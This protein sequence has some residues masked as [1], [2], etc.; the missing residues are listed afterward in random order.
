MRRLFLNG[1]TVTAQ[2][3]S[4]A[5]PPIGNSPTLCAGVTLPRR[6][7]FSCKNYTTCKLL[8]L[9]DA[10]DRADGNAL[11][12]VMVADAFNAGG[13]IDYIEGA[14]AFGDG[15]SGAIGHARAAGNTIVLNFHGHGLGF[16]FYFDFFAS[17]R[18]TPCFSVSIDYRLMFAGFCN[19]R[20]MIFDLATKKPCKSMH[21]FRFTKN[22]KGKHQLL[23]RKKFKAA[24]PP[25][26]QKEITKL[27]RK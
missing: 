14:I 3:G 17:S 11:G 8:G 21:G 2:K 10:I 23:F 19:I 18:Y 7:L 6:L 1:E 4:W 9:D 25:Q 22:I 27:T 16:L 24:R 5:L 15:F 26:T 13:L 20:Q 12:R